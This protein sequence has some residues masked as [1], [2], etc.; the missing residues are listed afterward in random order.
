MWAAV[1]AESEGSN[2]ATVTYSRQLSCNCRID[3]DKQNSRLCHPRPWERRVRRFSSFRARVALRNVPNR[4]DRLAQPPKHHMYG[5]SLA[6]NRLLHTN[7]LPFFLGTLL[8]R[9]SSF[10][11]LVLQTSFH[12]HDGLWLVL[13]GLPLRWAVANNKI[14]VRGICDTSIFLRMV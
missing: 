6:V 4:V 11:I 8:T 2:K 14:P 13:S 3:T 1:Q 9:I 7:I 10:P 5:V 12:I